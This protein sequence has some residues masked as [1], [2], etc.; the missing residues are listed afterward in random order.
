MTEERQLFIMIGFALTVF[1]SI[2]FL[3]VLALWLNPGTS[4]R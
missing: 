1:L 2:G 3:I 4:K